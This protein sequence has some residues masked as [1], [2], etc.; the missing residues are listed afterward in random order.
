MRDEFYLLQQLFG[1][2]AQGWLAAAYLLGLIA[3]LA[4]RPERIRL[5]GLFRWAC[6]LFALSVMVPPMLMALF[7]FLQ[8]VGSSA[9]GRSPGL[10]ASW[11]FLY[12]LVNGSGPVLLGVSLIC[13]L[14]AV[15]PG[16]RY[17]GPPQPPRHPLG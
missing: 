12:P 11:T 6:V 17:P 1:G 2:N 15:S 3:V 13:A 10:G 9:Y 8:S 4:Y 7:A 16:P 14:I 5:P